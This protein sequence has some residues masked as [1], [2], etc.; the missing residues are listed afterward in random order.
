MKLTGI[1]RRHSDSEMKSVKQPENEFLIR[2]V[3]MARYE[4]STLG[5][6]QIEWPHLFRD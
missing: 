3:F 1:L 5:A 2:V 6:E 4:A